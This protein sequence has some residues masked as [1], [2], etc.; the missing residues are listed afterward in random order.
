MVLREPIKTTDDFLDFHAEDPDNFVV[1]FASGA[2]KFTAV[3]EFSPPLELRPQGEFLTND[4]IRVQV[5]DNL[6]QINQ[7]RAIID[8]FSREF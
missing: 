2:D 7:L 3:L 5:R 8:G 6:T 4:Y 1:F